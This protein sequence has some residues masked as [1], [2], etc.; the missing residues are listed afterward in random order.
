MERGIKHNESFKFIKNIYI[1][2]LSLC[3][4]FKER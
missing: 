1:K 4:G 2:K 3:A